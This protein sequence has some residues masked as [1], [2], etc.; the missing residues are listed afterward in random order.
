ML[1]HEY[2]MTAKIV[3]S[4]EKVLLD[5]EPTMEEYSS[6]MLR[7]ERLNV[8][9][10]F[11]SECPYATKS[12]RIEVEG[13]LAPF[14]T[15]RSVEHVPVT[16]TAPEADDYYI[17]KRPGLYPDHLKEFKGLGLVIPCRQWKSVWVSLDGKGELLPAGDHTLT[18]TLFDEFNN[19]V[20][21]L[22]YTV[23]ILNTVSVENDLKIT[24]WM[25]YDS[26]CQMHR[27]KPFTKKFYQFF[28]KYLSTYVD[29]GMTMLLTPLFTPA[30]DTVVG[31]E[32]M[33]TQLVGVTVENG[34]YS[35][36]FSKLEEF[37]AFAK[38]KGIRYFEFSHLFTQ[39]GG[40]FCPKIMA[41]KNGKMQKIFGW[42]VSSDSA[43]YKEFLDAFLPALYQKIVDLGIKEVSYIHLTD[44]PGLGSLETYAKCCELVKHHMGGIQTMDAL[45]EPEFCEKGIV[46]IPVPITKHY[47]KFLKFKKKELIVYNCCFPNNGYYSLRFING[48]GVRMRIMGAQFY[49]TGA[50]GF[51]HWGFNFYSSVLSME[52]INPYAVTD[53]CGFFPGGDGFI[54]Y[55]T[56]KGVEYSL[57]AELMKESVQDYCALKTLESLTDKQTAQALLDEA[58]I[59]HYNEYPRESA[60]F[61]KFRNRIYETIEQNI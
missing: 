24:N 30:L 13:D 44:E 21:E 5:R 25:H 53:A 39:W 31:G 2:N 7:N 49:A 9:L 55:P 20:T 52:R 61:A 47:E 45:S 51:L 23:T 46:D 38:A 41:E 58:G 10:V 17:D 48:P 36:D 27:V 57:R 28:D 19:K 26:I 32:R 60:E 1:F 56:E 6:K 33:T 15:L 3:P 14:V 40:K 37:V 35:F 12:N 29:C 43:E 50:T 11:K 42:H 8:Q 34:K 54:V 18:F 4:F 16:Y 59:K 22:S